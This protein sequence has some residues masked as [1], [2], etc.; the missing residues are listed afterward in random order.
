M[1]FVLPDVPA[2]FDVRV[3]RREE[4][5]L[6]QRLDAVQLLDVRA[7]FPTDPRVVADAIAACL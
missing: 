5:L 1:R 3:E 4:E 2:E 7:P 6:A